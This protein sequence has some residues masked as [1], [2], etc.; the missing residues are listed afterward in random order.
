MRSAM[1]LSVF[2]LA[3][4]GCATKSDSVAHQAQT[5]PFCHAVAV[6]R[7]RDAAVYGYERAIMEAIEQYS[8]Q[9]CLANSR[10]AVLYA[11]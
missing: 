7:A 11:K 8:Y 5:D 4:G 6:A 9:S 1:I 2:V 10:T 3:L